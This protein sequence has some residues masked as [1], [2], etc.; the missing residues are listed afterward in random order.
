MSKSFAKKV[1]NSELF[2]EIGNL[3]DVVL[4]PK[5]H[6]RKSTKPMVNTFER[7]KSE[8]LQ[9]MVHEF[10]YSST[11]PTSTLHY[12]AVLDDV[13]NGQEYDNFG[14]SNKFQRLII[15]LFD[16]AV[17]RIENIA[18]GSVYDYLLTY[19]LRNHGS[20]EPSDAVLQSLDLP[21][22]VSHNLF[23]KLL[24]TVDFIND[25]STYHFKEFTSYQGR[26]NKF[27][28][29]R[30]DLGQLGDTIDTLRD[31]YYQ[32]GIPLFYETS[33]DEYYN[34]LTSQ[35]SDLSAKLS[36]VK[37][38]YKASLDANNDLSSEIQSLK[39]SLETSKNEVS[40]V[41]ASLVDANSKISDLNSKISDLN[42]V[43]KELHK[44]IA[45]LETELNAFKERDKSFIN[46][47]L[48]HKRV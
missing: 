41:R 24:A 3:N 13:M 35:I 43:N 23:S 47:V 32:F 2:N 7:E 11:S 16:K 30:F 46:R 8:F 36:S 42:T 1:N 48:S 28:E 10:S 22:Q 15:V 26:E 19:F 25:N 5:Y 29:L 14:V 40:L 9:E 33:R 4:P 18:F 21:V 39:T 44:V 31:F 17:E 38:D 20:F 6:K 34:V 45:S 27:S 37:T 12:P